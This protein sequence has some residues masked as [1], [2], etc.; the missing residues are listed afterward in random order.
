MR[1]TNITI[2]V[3]FHYNNYNNFIIIIYI[4]HKT[5]FCAIQNR[6]WVSNEKGTLPDPLKKH[7]FYSPESSIHEKLHHNLILILHCLQGIGTIYD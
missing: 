4:S 6:L 5:L 1:N 3:Y 2:L 7:F